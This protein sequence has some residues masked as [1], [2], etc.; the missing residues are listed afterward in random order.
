[1][2]VQIYSNLHAMQKQK[3][4]LY[5]KSEQSI[6]VQQV[7]HNHKLLQ[8]KGDDIPLIY[9]FNTSEYLPKLT[10]KLVQFSTTRQVIQCTK[11]QSL[12]K[13]YHTIIALSQ[14]LH[15]K[16][17]IQQRNIAINTAVKK[18]SAKRENYWHHVYPI[19]KLF[20]LDSSCLNTR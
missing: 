9:W 10:L 16:I 18:C 5:I 12:S 17:Q 7:D 2:F 11:T 19:L 3:M 20:P 1:M 13:K 14:S 4:F 8:H 15:K 6:C